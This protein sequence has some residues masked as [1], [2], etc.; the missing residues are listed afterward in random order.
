MSRINFNVIATALVLSVAILVI[1][2]CKGNK[3]LPSAQAG[4]TEVE[5]PFSDPKY[6]SNADFF[7]ASQSGR[8]PDLSTAKRIALMN[9]RTELGTLIESTMKVVTENYINQISVGDRQEYM[10][11]FEEQA[12]SVV[13]QTL[14]DVTI[15]GERTFKET[16][17]GFTYY[18]A[19]EMSKDALLGKLNT[20]ISKDERLQLDFNQ[21]RFREVFNEE[22]KKFESS[23]R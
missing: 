10:S 15:I 12:R 23:G 16:N 19:V 21:H 17:G 22:M 9:A 2:G 20:N 7:R 3:S 5:V 18:V 13:N 6:K 4:A 11:K 8:S 14:N 1:T